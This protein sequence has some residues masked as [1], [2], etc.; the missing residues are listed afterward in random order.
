MGLILEDHGKGIHAESRRESFSLYGDYGE[1]FSVEL[2][3]KDLSEF[4]YLVKKLV[5]EA[6]RKGVWVGAPKGRLR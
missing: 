2:E 5:T 6:K 4:S 1:G 3:W